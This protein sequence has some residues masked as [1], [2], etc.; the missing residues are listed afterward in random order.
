MVGVA[1]ERPLARADERRAPRLRGAEL[2]QALVDPASDLCLAAARERQLADLRDDGARDILGPPE[3][4]RHSG[5]QL[6]H[7]H[8]IACAQNCR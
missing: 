2:A 6:G 4:R 5:R 7:S 1:H 8:A 3:A